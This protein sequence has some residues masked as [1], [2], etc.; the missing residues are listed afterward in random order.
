MIHP[1]QLNHDFHWLL[2]MGRLKPGVTLEQANADMQAVATHVAL[3]NPKSNKGY[4]AGVEQLQNDFVDNN[5]KL[6]LWLMLGA[7]GFVLL[8]ACAN[9]ANLLL[10]RG[11][12]RQREVAIRSAVGAT[13]RDVFVQF[14][15]ESLA[16]AFV[17]GALGIAVGYAIL[18]GFIYFFPPDTLPS[19]ADLRLSLPVLLASIAATTLAGL[20]AGCAPAWYASRC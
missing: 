4:G 20:L 18:R 11:T 3:A 12:M 16:L 13:K 17:G 1:A 14:V 8:I 15:T 5:T 6:A 7:T 9:I 19:E 10:A 2:V